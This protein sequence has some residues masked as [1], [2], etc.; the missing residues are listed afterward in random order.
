MNII[1]QFPGENE[2]LI[3]EDVLRDF[4]G[5]VVVN[6]KGNR[7]VFGRPFSCSDIYIEVNG[8]GTVE[9]GSR[10]LLSGQHIRL[11]APGKIALGDGCAFNGTSHLHMHESAT[12]QLG[13]DCL[14]A[15]NTSFSS[16]HVHKI[17]D[18]DTG[19]RLNPA[20]DIIVGDH[21]WISADATLW[22]GAKVGN[23]SVVGKGSYV[24]KEFPANCIIAGTPA[25]VVRER[26]TWEG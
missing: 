2:I 3:A 6:G 12:I 21:V 10:C 18:L 1:E 11:F 24:S 20:G 26:I 9:V 15:G 8:G 4:P 23:D 25:R 5:N 19:E 22:P 13:R 16:S 7:V 17:L 14:I